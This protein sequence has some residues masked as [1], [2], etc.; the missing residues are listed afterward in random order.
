[1]LQYTTEA[2]DLEATVGA[3]EKHSLELESGGATTTLSTNPRQRRI[4]ICWE[5]LM[6]AR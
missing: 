6:S 4:S 5:V 2:A 3:M 1:M